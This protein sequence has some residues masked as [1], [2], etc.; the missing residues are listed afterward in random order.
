MT[1]GTMAKAMN[2]II[3]KAW[4]TVERQFV[5]FEVHPIA[6]KIIVGIGMINGS[7]EPRLWRYCSGY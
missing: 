7:P 1:E 6:E 5:I 2:M 4:F 3:Q